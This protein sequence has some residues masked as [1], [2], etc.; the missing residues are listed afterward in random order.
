MLVMEWDMKKRTVMSIR[1]DGSDVRQYS[2]YVPS[3]NSICLLLFVCFVL[4]CLFN[5]DAVVNVIWALS[6]QLMKIM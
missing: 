6:T 3:W 1:M 5:P 2:T 4:V